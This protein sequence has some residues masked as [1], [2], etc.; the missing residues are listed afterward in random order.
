MLKGIIF[1]R[2]QYQVKI[3]ANFQYF[4]LFLFLAVFQKEAHAGY[5]QN[6]YGGNPKTNAVAFSTTSDHGVVILGNSTDT[7]FHTS[8]YYVMRT[9]SNGQVLWT[10]IFSNAFSAYGYAITTLGNGNIVFLGTHSGIAFQN[11]AELMVVDSSGLFRSTSVYAP[12]NGWGTAGVGLTN[13][14]DTSVAITLFNDGF[15]SN[16][17]Y[18]IYSL[19]AD[20]STKWNDFVSFDGSFTNSHGVTTA[21]S[22]NIYTISY[23]DYYLFG[24]N[25]LFNVTSVRK[26][27]KFGN[28]L[29]D[30]I[31][32]FQCITTSISATADGG[33]I[34]SGIQD[35]AFQRDMVII[36]LDSTGN[37]LWKKQYGS[38]FDEEAFSVIQ[39]SD[40]GYALLANTADPVVPGQNDLL[41]MKM[42]SIGD[43]L[44]ARKFGG[45]LDERALHIAEERTDLYILGSTTSFSDNHILLIKTDSSGIVK[46]PYTITT[47][48]RYLC[49]SDTALLQIT[50][51]PRPDMHI[52]WSNGDTT[53]IAKVTQSG[54]YYADISDSTGLIIHTSFVA[55]YV[56][57]KPDA[58]FGPDTVSLCAGSA[59][60]AG[61]SAELTNT[62]EWF[63]NGVQIQGENSSYIIPQQAG[64]Y[65]LIIHNYCTNDTASSLVDTLY[66]LPAQPVIQAP[67]VD[68][69]CPGDSLRLSIPPNAG[70]TY[71][72]YTADDFN[73]YIIPGATDSV[74]FARQKGLYLVRATN[75]NDCSAYSLPYGVAFNTAKELINHQGP[76]SFCKGGEVLLNVSPGTGFVWSRGDTTQSIRVDSSGQYSVTF[77]NQYGCFKR[78]DTISITVRNNPEVNLGPDTTVCDFETVTLDAGHG[79]TNY[80][81]DNGTNAPTLNASSF[82]PFPKSVNFMVFVT[83]SNGC[84]DSDT[85]RINFDLC[86]GISQLFSE[87]YNLFPNPI[88]AREV[89]YI[90][91]PSGNNQ[92]LI[93]TD[94][95]NKEVYRRNIFRSGSVNIDE[96]LSQGMYLYRITK[97]RILVAS[98]KILV[99]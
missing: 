3:C 48:A 13:N 35:S 44:W 24:P 27:D 11:V 5:F 38:F 69:V 28:I 39:T 47:S 12:F 6:V 14:S 73:T 37:V 18:A 16:N 45:Y 87:T 59:L 71:Q 83:D 33:S 66:Q 30:S 56:A 7:T 64:V 40:G 86:N 10:K 68:Y 95:Q 74:Y 42:N 51:S 34:I 31:Y 79:F 72:W 43:S 58:S 97:N 53:N 90:T 88:H 4:L 76:T 89:L 15:I 70:Q 91:C 25:V 85:I 77:Y 19:N 78:S 17:Y 61:A 67:I 22:G 29:L 36:R 21:S 52:A 2:N 8:A 46:S 82:G 93:M 41:L 80:L 23:Y 50:P 63:L 81:W 26:H 32:D 49:E 99:H 62:Y 57:K 1:A 98:G 94:M 60:I 9:D 75:S 65:K 92:E 96:N 84:T 20:L 55:V 54:N